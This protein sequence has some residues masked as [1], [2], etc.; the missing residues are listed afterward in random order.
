MNVADTM[1]GEPHATAAAVDVVTHDA[2]A[3]DN[4][5]MCPIIGIRYHCSDPEC[6]DVDLCEACEAL[7]VHNPS[8]VISRWCVYVLHICVWHVFMVRLVIIVV[9]D[10]HGYQTTR[11]SRSADRSPAC[12][13]RKGSSVPV[14]VAPP[15]PECR[16]LPRR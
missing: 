16:P 9:F 11:W 13:D 10:V 7:D 6:F 14:P 15:L 5:D 8:T 4:C 1:A 2:V 12:G 3:C